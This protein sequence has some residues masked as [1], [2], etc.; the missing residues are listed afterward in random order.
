MEQRQNEKLSQ[1]ARA[2]ASKIS[3]YRNMLSMLKTDV[4]TQL[5]HVH[6]DQAN[7]IERSLHRMQTVRSGL[8][9]P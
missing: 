7:A 5:Q 2:V 1:L 6:Q 4:R 3:G 8:C 9:L